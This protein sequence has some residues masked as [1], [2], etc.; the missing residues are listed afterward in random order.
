MPQ[1]MINDQ[2]PIKALYYLDDSS[3]TVG[4]SGIEKIEPYEENGEQ[5]PV[6]WFEIW[7]NGAVSERVNAKYVSV[8][9]Y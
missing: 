9:Q 3:F 5:A 1:K 6:T 4:V 7:R 2:R 8:V